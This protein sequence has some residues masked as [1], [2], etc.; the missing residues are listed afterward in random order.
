MTMTR[1]IGMHAAAD[2][3][4]DVRHRS[5]LGRRRWARLIGMASTMSPVPATP[6]TRAVG[7]DRDVD[8]RGGAELVGLALL[9]DQ[10]AAVAAGR[11]ADRDERVVADQVA[12][13]KGSAASARRRTPNR[14]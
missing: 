1:K 10:H 9:L 4:E 7:P 13:E 12:I 2:E 14:T 3:V 11:D 5:L 6:I 8:R